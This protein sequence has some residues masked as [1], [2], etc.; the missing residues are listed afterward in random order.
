M[1]T[2]RWTERCWNPLAFAA[3][4]VVLAGCAAPIHRR[5]VPQGLLDA[6]VVQGMPADIRDWGDRPSPVLRKSVA[7]AYAQAASARD[8]DAPA[9]V[10]AISGGGS[11]GAYAAGLLCGWTASGNRPVFR[12]VT[13]V[14]VGALIAPLAFLGPGYDGRLLEMTRAARDDTIYRKKGLLLALSSDSLADNSPLIGYVA[15]FFDESLL[16]AVAAEHAKGRRLF[17]ATTNLDAKRP[18][19]WDMGAVASSGSPRALAVFREVIVASAAL[20]VAFPPTYVR[21]E[22]DG[23]RYD[24]MHVDGGVTEQ[25]ILYGSWIAGGD[26]PPRP[27]APAPTYYVIRNGK[28]TADWRPVEPTIP[29]IATNAL[30]RLIQAQAVGD[31]WQAYVTCRRDGLAFRLASIPEDV[32]IPGDAGFDPRTIAMLFDRG[33]A[34]S[35][36]GYPWVDRPPGVSEATTRPPILGTPAAPPRD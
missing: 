27:D 4:F 6:V 26:L 3:L 12:V 1:S 2:N 24:E 34:Q 7:D 33:F 11:N 23:Q 36:S 22:H 25:I 21:V 13:G 10:L 20:P 8:A 19:I 31:L 15:R 35:R 16:R 28:L 29:S 17:I 32:V 9:D 18:V 5:A 14:S 30:G